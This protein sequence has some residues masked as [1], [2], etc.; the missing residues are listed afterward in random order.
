[1]YLQLVHMGVILS[2]LTNDHQSL[3]NVYNPLKF[4]RLNRQS[5]EPGRFASQDKMVEK[6]FYSNSQ[7]FAGFELAGHWREFFLCY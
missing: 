2:C 4:K 5:N 6:L 3:K 7:S 1:M